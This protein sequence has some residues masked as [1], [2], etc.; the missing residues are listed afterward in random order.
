MAAIFLQVLTLN[1]GT[2]ASP[3]SL[4]IVRLKP[5]LHDEASPTTWL[6]EPAS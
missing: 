6:V 4:L 5:R 3:L 1:M 2:I